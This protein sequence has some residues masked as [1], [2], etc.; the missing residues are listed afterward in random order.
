MLPDSLP[1]LFS[2]S[3]PFVFLKDLIR[4]WEGIDQNAFW[5]KSKAHAFWFHVAPSGSC[6]LKPPPLF[7][8]AA[9]SF[10]LIFATHFRDVWNRKV[11][12]VS[13]NF[14]MAKLQRQWTKREFLKGE[15]CV[16]FKLLVWHLGLS[17]WFHL[18]TKFCIF[19]TP[20]WL[21]YGCT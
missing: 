20:L 5:S 15:I 21:F 8:F 4:R 19:S 16:S 13:L 17:A 11:D 9:I 7:R 14:Y 12:G 3:S 1:G 2:L 10:V 6:C 18:F